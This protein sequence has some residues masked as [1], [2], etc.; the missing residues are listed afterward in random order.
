MLF[1][2]WR[3]EETDL[4]GFC[5]SY[6]Q[7]CMLLS[8]MINEQMTQYAVC[9]EDF[10]EIQHQM[11]RMEETYDSIAPGTQKVEHQE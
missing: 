1:T 7:R 8:N 11:N 5:S 9:N 3:N 10:N 2:P 4:I 6:Q